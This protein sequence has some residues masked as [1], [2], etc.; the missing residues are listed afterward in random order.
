MTIIIHMIIIMI[1][2]IMLKPHLCP[3]SSCERIS[4][5]PVSSRT[6]QALKKYYDEDNYY[7]KENYYDEGNYYDEEN[8]C[9]EESR[10]GDSVWSQFK[11]L[12]CIF[13]IAILVLHQKS[14]KDFLV[15]QIINGL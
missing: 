7:N 3:N 9:D 4:S 15:N 6:D 1:M 11:F 5:H 8:Y 14:V 13:C 10:K 2:M 12:T